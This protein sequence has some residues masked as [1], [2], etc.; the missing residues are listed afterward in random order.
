MRRFLIRHW[1]LIWFLVGA[2][3]ALV[4]V[5][6]LAHEVVWHKSTTREPSP[7][8]P[9]V[10]EVEQ[11]PEGCHQNRIPG[12]PVAGTPAG[13]YQPWSRDKVFPYFV[14]PGIIMLAKRLN[15]WMR[16]CFIAHETRHDA[17]EDHDNGWEGCK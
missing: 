3:V 16:E 11:I 7:V 13:C 15:P 2:A 10:I 17:G 6:A 12:V 4:S 1:F 8:P 14:N 5:P 9:I